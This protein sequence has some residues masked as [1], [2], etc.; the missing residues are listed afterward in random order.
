MFEFEPE[1]HS[2]TL[3]GERLPSVTQIIAPLT[4]YSSVPVGVL[5]YARARGEAAH[6]TC[7]LWD[8]N[9]LD[10]DSLNP[11]LN[12]YLDAWKAFAQHF[13]PRW[14]TIETPI[15]SSTY[16]IAGTPDRTG[17]IDFKSVILEIKATAELMPATGVQLSGYDLIA[18][19]M[20]GSKVDEL[21]A[22]Q[23]R[24]DGTYRHQIFK[25]QR[26]TFLACRQYYLG[27]LG[28]AAWKASNK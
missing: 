12:G 13:K 3:D 18:E 22:V 16:R 9:D 20:Y 24:A 5:E 21:W 4:D 17:Q 10:M 23:I 26:A 2:Y 11:N 1:D 25:R 15:Y 7:E 28:I 14:G 6:R 8:K 19:E 27:S